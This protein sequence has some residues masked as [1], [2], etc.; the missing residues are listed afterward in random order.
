M[1][2]AVLKDA[3][4]FVIKVDSLVS[5]FMLLEKIKEAFTKLSKA[6]ELEVSSC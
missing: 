3:C 6:E 2:Q 5:S 1:R 4:K